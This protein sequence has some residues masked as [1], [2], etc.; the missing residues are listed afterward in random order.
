MF[1]GQPDSIAREPRDFGAPTTSAREAVET[2]AEEAQP[3]AIGPI[4]AADQLGI[5]IRADGL[6]HSHQRFACRV[7]SIHRPEGRLS[8]FL[9]EQITN[10]ACLGSS[11]ASPQ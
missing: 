6:L 10:D 9:N 11:A 5:E 4:P 7:F 3:M 1:G 2:D 8:I